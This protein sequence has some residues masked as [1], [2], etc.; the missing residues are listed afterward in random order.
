MGIICVDAGYDLLIGGNG[1]IV[2]RETDLLC[3]V[4]TEED[5]LEY[6]AAFMQL[7]REEG[8]YMERTAPYVERV[9][10]PHIISKIVTNET[11]RKAL[12]VR[13]LYSQSFTQIDPW[14]ERANGV[15]A[16]EFNPMAVVA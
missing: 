3:R 1:G 9:G 7:Y 2:L 8:H 5:V 13:F 10:M 11:T 4:S 12:A 14:A 6:A 16:D 15:E